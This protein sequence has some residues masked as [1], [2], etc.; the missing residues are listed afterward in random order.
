MDNELKY[1]DTVTIL[2]SYKNWSGGYLSVFGNGNKPGTKYAVVTIDSSLAI[3]GGIWRIESAMEK[4]IGSKIINNDIILLYNLYY[5][6]GGYLRYYDVV[7]QYEQSEEIHQVYTSDICKKS[8]LEWIIYCETT[9]SDGNIRAG[10]NVSLYNRWGNKG[11][12]DTHNH[13]GDTGSLYQVFMSNNT[14]RK[15]QTGL[16]KMTKVNNPCSLPNI[17]TNPT[18]LWR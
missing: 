16:W 5:C 6:D 4:P 8:T 2:N 13:A 1:G 14:T 12:L 10:E 11:F 7:D 3:H 9:P 15:S 17:F 18:S